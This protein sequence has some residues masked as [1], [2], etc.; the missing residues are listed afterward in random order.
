MHTRPVTRAVVVAIAGMICV[1]SYSKIRCAIAT[2]IIGVG[3]C[4]SCKVCCVRRMQLR[5]YLK[6]SIS[7]RS[8][9][10]MH[11]AVSLWPGRNRSAIVAKR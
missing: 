7:R 8:K 4:S 3:S 6:A 11:Y 1:Q 2:I 9:M 5:Y 10:L